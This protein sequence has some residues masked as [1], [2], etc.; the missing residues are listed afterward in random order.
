MTS[1]SHL[2]V[3]EEAGRSLLFLDKLSDKSTGLN[4]RL[5]HE[6]RVHA[7]RL[8]ASLVELRHRAEHQQGVSAHQ[9]KAN[10]YLVIEN[11]RLKRDNG[12]IKGELE[13]ARLNNRSLRVSVS[14]KGHS[15]PSKRVRS[16]G[17]TREMGTQTESKGLSSVNPIVIPS[18]SSPVFGRKIRTVDRCCSPVWG[19]DL[20]VFSRLSVCSR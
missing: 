17:H 16:S 15:P 8:E 11:K 19:V 14:P 18:Q 13:L 12:K 2:D 10:D 6:L 20:S 9:S 4:S 1:C 7:R 5:V 3:E